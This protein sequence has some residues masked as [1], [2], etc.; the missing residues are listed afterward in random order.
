MKEKMIHRIQY[1]LIIGFDYK[2]KKIKSH[3]FPTKPH[4]P[5]NVRDK[6][7]NKTIKREK[8]GLPSFT[9]GKPAHTRKNQL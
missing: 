6:C 4:S 9:L 1:M 3:L 7:K 8:E 5:R 2:K